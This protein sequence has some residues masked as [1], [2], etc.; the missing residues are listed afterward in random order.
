[1]IIERLILFQ[2]EK[3]QGIMHYECVRPKVQELFLDMVKTEIKKKSRN[4][5][6]SQAELIFSLKK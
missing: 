6:M 4:W 1:M 5:F 2:Q 3:S